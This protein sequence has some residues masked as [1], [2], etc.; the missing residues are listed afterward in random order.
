MHISAQ[1]AWLKRESEISSLFASGRRR[2]VFSKVTMSGSCCPMQIISASSHRRSYSVL[3]RLHSVVQVATYHFVNFG[4]EVAKLKLSW[5]Q[6]CNLRLCQAPKQG[7]YRPQTLNPITE[8]QTLTLKPFRLSNPHEAQLEPSCSLRQILVKP[9]SNCKKP[10]QASARR[11]KKQG[12]LQ[13]LGS[14]LPN[15]GRIVLVRKMDLN[16]LNPKPY[17]SEPSILFGITDLQ[18]ALLVTLTVSR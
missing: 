13:N 1:Y 15:P 11:R 8:L 3:R 4:V 6:P 2:Q 9:T 12:T 16:P 5:P 14:Q 17:P 18:K 7:N 10:S